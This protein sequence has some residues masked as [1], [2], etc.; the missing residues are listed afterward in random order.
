MS[1]YVPGTGLGAVAALDFSASAVWSDWLKGVP[2]KYGGAGDN[3]AGKRAANA[4]RAALGFLAFGN[5]ISLDA[6][7][8]TPE[9]QASYT[10]F[11]QKHGVAA[12]AGLPI[13]WPSKPGL[14]KLEE[15]VK[16]GVPVGGGT[17]V[18]THKVGNEYVTGPAP[19]TGTGVAQ[20][21]MSPLM[22]GALVAAAVVVG[23]LAIAA[24]RKKKS[25]S[26]YEA[27]AAA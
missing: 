11:A 26:G 7:W 13:W 5:G 14:I 25:S 21:G 19:G 27:T 9:D 8:G 20:A 4:I 16:V 18:L 3:A 24:K 6:M 15:L 12:P 22:I 23:G 1:Y 17:Q 2:V 10:S